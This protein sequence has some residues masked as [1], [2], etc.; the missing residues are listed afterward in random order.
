MRE[1][2]VPTQQP[3]TS[4]EPRLP[5]PHVDQS[6]AGRPQGEAAEGPAPAVGL[7]WA[8][9][10]RGTFARFRASRT[11]TTVGPITVIF[12]ADEVV[13]RP[14]VAYSVGRKVG[15]AVVRNQLRRRLRA[16]VTERS[17]RLAPG[18][19][20][21]SAGPRAAEMS[22][23]DLRST[24]DGVFDRMTPALTPRADHP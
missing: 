4:Q 12:V 5:S 22:F 1:T 16:I 8:V 3:Q 18:A 2:H 14:R 11:R 9:R 15:T 23:G 21:I 13:A 10:D 19:Y 24:V 20:L 6:G 17:A 7:T